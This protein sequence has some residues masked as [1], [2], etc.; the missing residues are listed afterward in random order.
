MRPEAP[1]PRHWAALARALAMGAVLPAA[2]CALPGF[3]CEDPAQC[4]GGQCQ[5][6]GFCSFADPACESGQRYGEH[7]GAHS[8]ACVPGSGGSDTATTTTTTGAHGSSSGS[9]GGGGIEATTLP[10]LRDMGV[11]SLDGSAGSSDSG[12]AGLPTPLL[13]FAFDEP[14]AEGLTNDGSLG[15]VATCMP[16]QCPTPMAGPQGLAGWFDGVDDCAMVPYVEALDVPDGLTIAAWIQREGEVLGYQGVLTKPVGAMSYNSWR[17]A[18]TN[19]RQGQLAHFHVGLV[20]DQGGTVTTPLPLST[21]SLVVGTWD[22][23]QLV[24]WQDGELVATIAN[25]LYESDDQGV[26]LGCDDEGGEVGITRFFVGGLDE[27]RLWDRALD[28]AEVAM[29]F[30]AG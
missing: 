2:G 18:V 22:R 16:S 10:Q 13:W 9:S 8:G 19:D 17:L 20:D 30:A 26:F 5:P 1:C 29:I 24:L 4:D 3:A 7:A 21:W 11:G 27:V 14:A 25:A 12:G 15:G 23:E 6:D 28:D